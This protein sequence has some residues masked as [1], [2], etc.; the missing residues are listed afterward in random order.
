MTLGEVTAAMSFLSV[1]VAGELLLLPRGGGP[2]AGGAAGRGARPALAE[3]DGW[4]GMAGGEVRDP[5]G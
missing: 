4:G 3:G 5:G 1:V 2:G